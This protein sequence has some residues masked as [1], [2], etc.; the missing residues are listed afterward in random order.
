MR[1]II[2]G[3]A[4]FVATCSQQCRRP[5]T[6]PTIIPTACKAEPTAT[7]G[8]VISQ[9]ISSARL[10]PP[11][12]FRFVARTLDLRTD[13]SRAADDLI[14]YGDCSD[15]RDVNVTACG[16]LCLHR[17]RINISTVLAGQRLGIK[18]VDEG[19]WL[20]SFAHYDPGYFGPRAENAA[21]PRQPF[22]H[23]VVTH[24]L[25][26]FCHPCVRAGQNIDW[27]AMP[28]DNEHYVYAIAL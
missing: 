3:A 19:I 5:L 7:R 4:A 10:R 28:D 1:N 11:A 2:I 9:A 27:R 15:D 17:K 14:R 13:R 21:T 24:V 20:V 6:I 23:E 18:E 8:C 22:R 16:R 25:G 26:T 12:Q